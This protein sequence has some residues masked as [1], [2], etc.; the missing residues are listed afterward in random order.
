MI[1]GMITMSVWSVLSITRWVMTG[2]WLAVMTEPAVSPTISTWYGGSL[3]TA[4]SN[5]RNWL[6]EPITS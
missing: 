3:G 4:L 5:A 1:D 6:I 2:T